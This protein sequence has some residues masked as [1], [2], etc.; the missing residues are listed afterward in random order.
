MSESLSKTNVHLSLLQP[1]QE[2]PAV[3]GRKKVNRDNQSVIEATLEQNHSLQPP[4]LLHA[5]DSQTHSDDQDLFA[6]FIDDDNSLKDGGSGDLMINDRCELVPET[7]D[8]GV[9]TFSQAFFAERP[10]QASTRKPSRQT[11]SSSGMSSVASDELA[12]MQKEVESTSISKSQGQDVSPNRLEVSLDNVKTGLFHADDASVSSSHSP[13]SQ[14]RPR[15]QANTSSRMMP[16]PVSASQQIQPPPRSRLIRIKLPSQHEKLDS[17]LQKISGSVH[18]DKRKLSA[19]HIDSDLASKKQRG[20]SPAKPE[21]SPSGSRRRSPRSPRRLISE[22]GLSE[23]DGLHTKGNLSKPSHSRSQGRSLVAQPGISS[24]I[25]S[26]T[27]NLSRRQPSPAHVA[28]PKRHSSRV[29]R[30]Q[31]EYALL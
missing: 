5:E 24:C 8:Q 20:M 7:Q 2:S 16:P 30:N 3:K 21:T 28:R 17:I 1:D 9:S 12:Q 31:S 26:G 4:M 27:A 18:S 11:P 15:S 23:G 29:T 10:A 25:S 6:T 19:S 14:E 22:P 13:R